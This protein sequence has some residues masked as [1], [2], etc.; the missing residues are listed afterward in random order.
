MAT[1]FVGREQET[2]MLK[3]L[4][5][6][7]NPQLVAI[8]GRRRVGKTYLVRQQCAANLVFECSGTID[9]STAMQL[10]H[11]AQ[12]LMHHFGVPAAATPGNWSDAFFMLEQC[13]NSLPENKK[14]VVFFDEF[15][16]LDN[17]RSGFLAAFTYWW[18][19]YGSRRRNLVTIICGSATSWMI[20]RVVNNK[21][22]LHNRITERIHLS[23]FTLAETEIYL[24]SNG[25]K[26]TRYQIAQ[27]YMVMGG[28]PHYLQSVKPG[29][30]VEQVINEVCFNK[31][32]LLS[33]EFHNLY[34]ALFAHPEK[35]IAL[36]KLLAGKRGGL[37]RSQMLE[38]SRRLK[39]G[40]GLSKALDEL[41][42]CGFVYRLLPYQNRV[43]ETVYR[44]ADEY[45]HF[46]FR[47]LASTAAQPR[48][49]SKIL[50]T[51][52]FEQW[53]GYAFETLCLR[54]IDQMKR[55]LGIGG[56]YTT[57]SSWYAKGTSQEPGAQIDLVIETPFT[58]TK[59][60]ADI[61]WQKEQTFRQKTQVRKA[62]FTTLIAPFGVAEND[63]RVQT[64]THTL[65]LNCFFN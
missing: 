54:H 5:A 61:L 7:E 50:P 31:N 30:S 37:T 11:F 18:N 56:V 39:S 24:K 55:G 21:G 46:Y 41:A 10:A 42:E 19:M 43:K 27:L 2:L 26:L 53:A 62:L 60:H 44:L 9:G 52:A 12:R 15:P 6:G 32:G 13:I 1:T 29:L 36:V 45:T 34:A 49:W 47:F 48:E 28:I 14:K 38:A 63:Y 33:S 20:Q 65:D 22:G 25:V 8:L 16:W 17:H 3:E 58:V 40:G 51:A 59:K 35:H 4:M 23:P 57:Q 64:V